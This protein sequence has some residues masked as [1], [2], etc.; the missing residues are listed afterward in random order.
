ML[1]VAAFVLALLA[2]LVLHELAHGLVALWN[3]DGTA[4]AYGRLSLNPLRHFD[5]VGLVLMLLVGFGW[6]RPVPVNPNNFRNR[7]TGAITVSIAGIVTNLILAFLSALAFVLI[8]RQAST[9][10]L[11]YLF[12]FLLVTSQLMMQLNV[13][14]A[15]FNILPLY[16]LDGYRLLSCFVNENNRGMSFLRRYSLY[17][18][19]GLIVLSHLPFVSDFSPL[20]LYLSKFGTLIVSGFCKFWGLI[21]HV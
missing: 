21:F 18:L 5:V 15:L 16:P 6:A 17:I 4:K 9:E 20:N 1:N 7:K 11:Y 19:L 3:G 13:S 2:A 10:S 8:P 12:Y 14:F